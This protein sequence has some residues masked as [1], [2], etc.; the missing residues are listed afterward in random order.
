VLCELS[1]IEPDDCVEWPYGRYNTGYPQ[2]QHEGKNR[3]GHRLVCQWA[4]GEPPAQTDAAHSCGNRG[5]V[6]PRHLRWATRRENCADT[7]RHGRQ[8]RGERHGR[9]KLTDDQ[10]REIR[11]RLD[12]GDRGKDLAAAFDVSPATISMIKNRFTHWAP[13]P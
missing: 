12:D 1:E 5:C 4:H 3:G 13:M 10:V 7:I 9:A 11:R 8:A 2:V 6:N